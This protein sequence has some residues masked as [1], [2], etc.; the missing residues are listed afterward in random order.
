MYT[1]II[2][3][4]IAVYD[5]ETDKF[6][7]DGRFKLTPSAEQALLDW[8][9]YGIS[10]KSLIMVASSFEPSED[11]MPVTPNEPYHQKGVF[12]ALMKDED[13]GKWVPVE[14]RLTYDWRARTP[15]PGNFASSIELSNIKVDSP[16]NI[17]R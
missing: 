3:P 4:S 2:N 11:Y 14:A 7:G 8:M 5:P 6:L 13:T 16:I 9:N 17:R 10:P 15:Q 1:Q 12:R